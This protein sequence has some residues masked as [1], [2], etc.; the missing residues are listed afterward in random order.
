MMD[1]SMAR[2][3]RDFDELATALRNRRL[4]LGMSQLELDHRSGLPDG[5]TAKLELVASNPTAKNAR[6]IGRLSLPLMLEALG[7][8]LIVKPTSHQDLV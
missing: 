6:N 1:P 3:V 8:T 7:L 2:K 5:Y 4:E